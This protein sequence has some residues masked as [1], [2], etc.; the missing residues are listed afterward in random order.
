VTRKR[1]GL[2][3]VL[4]VRAL[5][6][7]AYG[8]VAS[9]VWFALGVVSLYALGLTPWV[10]LAM[11][12]L[13]MVVALAYAEGIAA[14]PE[15][16]GAGSFVRRAFNDPAGFAVGWVIVLDYLIVIALAALFIPHY[17]GGAL[18]FD[19]ITDGPWDAV[20]AVGVIALIAAV[21]LV[22]R[23]QMYGV[24]IG[25]AAFTAAIVALVVVLALALLLSPGDLSGGPFPSAHSLLFALALATLA[26]TGLETVGNF[27][28]EA[29]EPGTALP[30]SLFYGLF[31]AVVTTTLAGIAWLA[32]LPAGSLLGSDWVQAPLLGIVEGFRAELPEPAVDA[33]RVFIG[34]SAAAVLVG[35]ITTSISGAGRLAFVLAQRQMLPRA[36]GRLSPRTLISPVT[37][38][39]VA[40]L[41]SG[42]LVI[43]AA[44]GQ[45]TRFLASL[46]SFGIMLAFTAGQAA[47]IRLRVKEPD[48]ERPFRVR[49]EIKVR[50]YRLP[51]PTLIALPITAVLWGV[52]LA[53]H[54]G[55]RVAGPIWLALGVVVYVLVRRREREGVFAKVEPA[56]GDLVPEIEGVYRRIL[57]PLKGGAI[58]DE[59]LATGLKLASEHSAQVEVMHVVRVPL[60]AA[61]DEGGAGERE[62]EADLSIHEAKELAAEQGVDIRARVVRARSIG[63]AIVD[64]ARETDADV[65]LL[66]SAPRW[67]RQSRFFSP[68]VDHVLRHAN[69]EVMVVAYPEG[70]LEDEIE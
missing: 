66:G 53:T 5:A 68:T 38:L 28:A 30:K 55:A 63:D 47:V 14:M 42:L 31:A 29:R 21:R 19:A 35:V 50:G 41:A 44:H 69:C 57:V 34:L 40:G 58:G 15:P 32:A 2:E 48:L 65:I 49:P 60:D 54:A 64:T 10:L 18:G 4:G 39:S 56:K 62:T 9:S 8:E 20:T 6:A 12:L 46:Y 3:R 67:R 61:L 25:L 37:I 33:L 22:R 17:L 23:T 16:G 45:P 27:A 52:A 59:V 51:L 70:V 13:F 11:G 26:Y 7:I 43:A 36:F 1:F 24:V